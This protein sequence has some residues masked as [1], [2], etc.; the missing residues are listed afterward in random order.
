MST[1][2]VREED[3]HNTQLGP[4]IPDTQRALSGGEAE[5]SPAYNHL[6][7]LVGMSPPSLSPPVGRTP[8]QRRSQKP[9]STHLHRFL[10]WESEVCVA[11]NPTTIVRDAERTEKDLS[12]RVIFFL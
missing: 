11:C 10:H 8:G 9:M 1:Q 4:Y 6:R 3:Y 5:R 7:Q 12:G 2:E